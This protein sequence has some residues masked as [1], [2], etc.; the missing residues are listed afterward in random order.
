MSDVT[1]KLRA[2][3]LSLADHVA[4]TNKNTESYSMG[5]SNLNVLTKTLMETQQAEAEAN[6]KERERIQAIKQWERE[7]NL[8]E[9]QAEDARD[10]FMIRT[11]ADSV[12]KLIQTAVFVDLHDRELLFEKDDSRSFRFGGGLMS[13]F[14]F[15]K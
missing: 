12:V 3:T 4:K 10:Q 2:E 11:I 14:P 8:K 9:A 1:E 7:Q 15:M 13:R 5:V 6:R